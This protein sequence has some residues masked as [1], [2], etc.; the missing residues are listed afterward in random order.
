MVLLGVGHLLGSDGLIEALNK[1]WY[2]VD[3]L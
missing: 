3:K 2:K 1:K